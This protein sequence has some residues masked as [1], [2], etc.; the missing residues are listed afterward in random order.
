MIKNVFQNQQGIQFK[1][2]SG[3]EI[4]TKENKVYFRRIFKVQRKH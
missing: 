1:I 2:M 4:Q 3:T